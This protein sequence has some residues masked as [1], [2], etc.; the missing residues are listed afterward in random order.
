MSTSADGTPAVLGPLSS[1]YDINELLEYLSELEAIDALTGLCNLDE[2]DR[3]KG[4][5]R[6]VR[7]FLEKP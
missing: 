6:I 5:T 1:P 2:G 3:H 7:L 4:L